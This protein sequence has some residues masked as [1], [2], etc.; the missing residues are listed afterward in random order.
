[1]EKN[2]LSERTPLYIDNETAQAVLVNNSTL[3]DATF[4]EIF[5]HLHYPWLFTTRGY[6]KDN[7]IILYINDY[8][9]PN[10]NVSLLQYLFTYFP[11]IDWI[12]LGCIKGDPGEW[13][14]P[15]LVVR[16]NNSDLVNENK[17]TEA[18]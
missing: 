11:N 10:I 16:R 18:S 1:M 2:F 7:H 6:I 3:K 17:S 8:D 13:W 14:K 5:S 15:R 9:I 4:A 12:G